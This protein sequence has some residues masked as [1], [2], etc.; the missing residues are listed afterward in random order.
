MIDLN[1][2]AL[3][4]QIVEA[5]GF[6]AAAKRSGTPLSTIS[7]KFSNLEARLGVRLIQRS[8]RHIHLTDVGSTYYAHCRRMLDEAMAAE[9]AIQKASDE[10]EGTIRIASPFVLD[11]RF[12]SNLL[13]GYLAR[14]PKMNLQVSRVR[15][16]VPLIEGGFD[17]GIQI[18]K[19]ADS[20]NVVRGL[21][22]DQIILCASPRYL[23]KYGEPKLVSDL[24]QHI[25][26]QDELIPFNY[27]HQGGELSFPLPCRFLHDDPTM[28]KSLAVDGVGICYLSRTG[29]L[30][31]LDDGSLVHILPEVQ[32]KMEISFVYPSRKQLSGNLATFLDY[33]LETFENSAPWEFLG[34][35]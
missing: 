22:S 10:P 20:S 1:E 33:M 8:T 3:F 31:N 14:F 5:K 32:Y 19:L 15:E 23:E 21:G 12:A 7:R 6:T 18:G 30:D 2:M 16:R 28:A 25:G 17:C 35:A 4:T 11:S 27:H 24:S 34:S 26:L 9:D 29:C 13:A